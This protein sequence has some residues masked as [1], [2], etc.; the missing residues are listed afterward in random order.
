MKALILYHSRAGHTRRAAEAVAGAV[1][2]ARH[3]AV[4]KSVIEV[5][6]ADIAQADVLFVGV[7]VQGYILLGVKPAGAALWAPALPPLA[8]K[9]IGVFCTYL[10]S[11]QGSL[12]QL[13]ALLEARGGRVV[14]QRAFRRTNPG[15]GAEQFARQAL[16][17]AGR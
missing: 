12:R 14:A 10:F 9:P 15:A 8:G 17:A 1:R 7:W 16:Q 11:P 2:A 4:V 13:S 5:G 6:P 3:S